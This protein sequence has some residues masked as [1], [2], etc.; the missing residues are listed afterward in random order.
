MV[1]GDSLTTR[2]VL[3]ES[4]SPGHA[5]PQAQT[6][7]AAV[8]ANW[9][10]CKCSNLKWWLSIFQKQPDIKYVRHKQIFLKSIDKLPVLQKWYRKLNRSFCAGPREILKSKYAHGR[11]AE[12]WQG[13]PR[14][15]LVS[16]D[17]SRGLWLLHWLETKPCSP[18]LCGPFNNPHWIHM[19]SFNLHNSPGR[20]LL[21]V[22]PFYRS[23]DWDSRRLMTCPGLHLRNGEQT[24]GDQDVSIIGTIICPF[25][26]WKYPR[27][28]CVFWESISPTQCRLLESVVGCLV[29]LWAPRQ[30]MPAPAL[31]GKRTGTC[32]SKSGFTLF[33]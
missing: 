31:R 8:F 16:T 11:E 29:L 21:F 30:Q 2:C 24:L 4:S 22:I 12:S 7:S 28:F 23:G 17:E 19:S 15:Q 18:H 20:E 27:M 32:S 14:G 6:E 13:Y 3:L 5:G 25:D 1:S 9:L 33:F 26:I 10:G